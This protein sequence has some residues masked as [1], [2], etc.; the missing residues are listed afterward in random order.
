[1]TLSTRPRIPRGE[2]RDAPEGDG[3]LS[4]ERIER[5]DR[6]RP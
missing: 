5:S 3:Y 2:R 6:R 1:V 4:T